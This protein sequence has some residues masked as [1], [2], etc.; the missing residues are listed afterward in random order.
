M[1]PTTERL[2]GGFHTLLWPGAATPFLL[3][4]GLSSN[5]RTWATVGE[6]L[7]QG[8]HAVAAVDLRGHGQSHKPDDGYD[9]ATFTDDLLG[10]LDALG[11]SRAV[12]AGQSTGGNLAVELAVKAPD[13]V[14]GV[15]GVD[16]GLI[17]L[18]GQ[19]EDWDECEEELAPPPLAGR[20]A[21]EFEGML[22]RFHPQWS[23]EGVAATLANCEVRADGTVH[24]WLTPDRH[25]RIL[26]ALWEQRPFELL[27]RLEA[28][29]LLLLADT[30]DSWATA[31]REE[32]AHAAEV[33]RS[34]QVVWFE[35]GDHDLHVERPATIAGVLAGAVSDGFLGS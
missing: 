5:G 15:V 7:H 19:F 23:D 34:L 25:M 18:S 29:L 1:P 8:G 14:A 13:R 9:F 30:G 3:V 31:K 20:P 21:V 26:R 11:W 27:S 4:H 17:N 12:V 28:P 10:V 33:A 24:P 2:S 35:S 16:G 32:V 6:V 22:R